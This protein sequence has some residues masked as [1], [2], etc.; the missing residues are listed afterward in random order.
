MI[1]PHS[2]EWNNDWTPDLKK[3]W[4]LGWGEDEGQ[5]E[6]AKDNTS[7]T[8]FGPSCVVM[9]LC[10]LSCIALRYSVWSCVVFAVCLVLSYYLAVVLRCLLSC[11][12]LCLCYLSCLALRCVVFGLWSFVSS[13]LV[14][15]CPVLCCVIL[16]GLALSSK[17]VLGFKLTQQFILRIGFGVRGKGWGLGRVSFL[18]FKLAAHQLK[19]R[20][21][22]FGVRFR[23]RG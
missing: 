7:Q 1:T 15:Y 11:V 13:C 16:S 5:G 10:C 14:F 19:D 9:C 8:I 2:Q 4:G 21:K 23:V 12:V 20:G 18:V 17:S 22:G 6:K 3:T